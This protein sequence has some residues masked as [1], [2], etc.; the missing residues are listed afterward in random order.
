MDVADDD[1]E[2]VEALFPRSVVLGWPVIIPGTQS[3]YGIGVANGNILGHIN[4]VS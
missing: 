1:H 4:V 3:S 2:G